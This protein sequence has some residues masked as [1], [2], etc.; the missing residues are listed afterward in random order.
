M[1]A[2]IAFAPNGT[3]IRYPSHPHR[4]PLDP[5]LRRTLGLDK[6]KEVTTITFTEPAPKKSEPVIIPI[7]RGKPSP[8]MS[9]E[10]GHIRKPEK[11]KM[12]TYCMGKKK[13]F[14]ELPEEKE[15]ESHGK[16][17]RKSEHKNKRGPRMASPQAVYDAAH[18]FEEGVQLYRMSH[19]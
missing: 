16:R 18:T 5:G 7:T 8:Q 19:R 3:L 11:P 14:P 1:P 12:R 9:A 4:Q 13:L 6:D 2:Q 10:I 15:P 17:G